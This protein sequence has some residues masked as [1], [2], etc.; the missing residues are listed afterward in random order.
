MSYSFNS[1]I[2]LLSFDVNQIAE[3]I[4]AEA[5]SHVSH[6]LLLELEEFAVK[7]A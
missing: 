2:L 1:R 7:D 6:W 5:F 3:R 4:R